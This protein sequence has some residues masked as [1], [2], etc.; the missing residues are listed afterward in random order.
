[1][2]LSWAR[3]CDSVMLEAGGE[4]C[5]SW[6]IHGMDFPAFLSSERE[7]LAGVWTFCLFCFFPCRGV[8]K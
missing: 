1:M 4:V 5:A 3:D 6:L 7:M 8:W 2:A